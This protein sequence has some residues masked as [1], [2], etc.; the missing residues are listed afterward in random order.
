MSSFRK[1]LLSALM[2]LVPFASIV[3]LSAQAQP[4]PADIEAKVRQAILRLP[5]YGVF[6]LLSFQVKGDTV[7]IGGAVY[8]AAL[9]KD[10]V[11]AVKSIPGVKNVVDKIT[12]LPVSIEDDQIRNAVF[13][14]IYTD[15]FLSKYGTPVGA[16]HSAR[17]RM[18]GTGF[19]SWPGF[20]G[21]P[22]GRTPFLGME[23][24][25][26]YAIHIIVENGRVTLFG[27]V[28]NE[29]DKAKAVMDARTVFGVKEVIDQLQV[30]AE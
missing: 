11:D 26:N 10:A 16:F 17:R 27:V 19:G 30:S 15:D 8:H 7:V 3:T 2:I 24:L 25:G 29:A 23:P 9:K 13:W 12:V 18:W 28:N 5:Y 21:G 22:W 14:K 20:A 1:L 4:A 6:D